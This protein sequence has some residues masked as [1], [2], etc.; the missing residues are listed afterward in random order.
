MFN[1]NESSTLLW[2]LVEEDEL[3]LQVLSHHLIERYFCHNC[4]GYVH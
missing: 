1:G 4:I 2:N 3:S